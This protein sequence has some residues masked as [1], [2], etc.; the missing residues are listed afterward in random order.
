M[1]LRPVIICLTGL[2]AAAALSGGMLSA[3]EAAAQPELLPPAGAAVPKADAISGSEQRLVAVGQ[4][5]AA[6]NS[7]LESLREQHAQLKLQMEALGIAAVKGDERS[8][9]QRLLKATSELSA[10]EKARAEQSERLNRLAE[11]ASAYMARPA[12][13]ALKT[14]LEEAIKAATTAKQPLAPDPVPVESARVV[15]WKSELGLAVVNAGRD[16]GL[17]M[18][19]PMHIVRGD[20]QIASGLVVDVRDRVAGIFLT[21]PGSAAVRPGDSVRPELTRTPQRK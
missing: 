4:A 17:R 2:A 10:S 5:L 1:L 7:E 3:Q 18:G 14:A 9:Q 8:L 11:A 16:S 21:G 6:A 12:E 20:K 19:T 15:S 13:P